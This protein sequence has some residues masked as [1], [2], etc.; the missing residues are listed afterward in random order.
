MSKMGF[1]VYIN[2]YYLRAVSTAFAFTILFYVK[3]TC[4]LIINLKITTDY[5]LFL[6]WLLKMNF[7]CVVKH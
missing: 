4:G 7:F 3:A 1:F 5:S 6:L 2:V